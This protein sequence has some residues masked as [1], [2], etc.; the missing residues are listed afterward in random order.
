MKDAMDALPNLANERENLVP[1]LGVLALDLNDQLRSALAPLRSPSGVV[2]VARV[3][4]FRSSATGLQAGDIIHS[5][6]QVSIDSLTALR[7]AL[8]EINPHDSAVLQVERDGGYQWLAF[9]ME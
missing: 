2:V 1:R 9:E 6:N 7:A 8:R 4:D 3:Q 5:L